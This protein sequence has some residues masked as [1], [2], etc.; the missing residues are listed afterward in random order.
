MPFAVEMYMDSVAEASV[1]KLCESISEAGLSS[2]ML[3]IGA[4]PHV[5]LALFKEIDLIDFKS[6][7]KSFAD[8]TEPFEVTFASISTFPTEEGVVFLA[9]I[10]TQ[11]LLD[12]HSRF[13]SEF[14]RYRLY[15]SDHY[16]PNRWVPHCTVCM[17]LRSDQIS[18]VIDVC[19]QSHFPISGRF[20]Q[21]GVIEYRPVKELFTYDLKR[22]E[23]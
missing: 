10:V 5:S 2:F 15:G 14:S 8:K 6:E 7:L 19:R 1:W 4:R 3:K 13:H 17:D 12:I 18:S 23:R 21:V 22:G 20:E 9:P 11:K 16:L